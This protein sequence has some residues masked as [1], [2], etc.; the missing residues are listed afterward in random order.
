MKP[1]LRGWPMIRKVVLCLFALLIVLSA[2]LQAQF[3]RIY[4][5][6]G[7]DAAVGILTTADGGFLVM[8]TATGFTAGGDMEPCLIKLAADG[9]VQWGKAYNPIGLTA[10]NSICQA[11]DGGYLM[12]GGSQASVWLAKTDS[13][14]EPVWQKSLANDLIY[15]S[16]YYAVFPAGDAG[17]FVVGST[18]SGDF[19]NTW[20]VK[21]S[22]SGDVIWQR[23][24]GLDNGNPGKC[25]EA[26][27]DGGFVVA[28]LSGSNKVVAF[29]VD[30]LG[31][32]SWQKA[33]AALD[34]ANC[35]V[36]SVG[37]SEGGG[38]ILV[39]TLFNSD[40]WGGSDNRTGFVYKV[41]EDGTLQWA[42][43][44]AGAYVR[45]GS[46]TL[47]GGA[48]AVG[49]V[50]AEASTDLLVL[51]LRADGEI[52]W[53]KAFGGYYEEDGAT[54]V[55]TSEG[56]YAAAGLT[57]SFGAG[58]TDILAVHISPGG[59][60]GSCQFSADSILEGTIP[61]VTEED[62]SLSGGETAAG[63]ETAD[64]EVVDMIG[65][66]ETYQLCAENKLLTILGNDAGVPASATTPSLGTH[67]YANNEAV[68]ISAIATYLF[69]GTTY[70]FSQWE[71]DIYES[72]STLTMTM[73]DDTTI[74]VWYNPYSDDDGG[75]DTTLEQC[76]VATA[77][78]RSPLHP[79]VKL[80]REFRDRRLLTNGA[81]R[82]LVEA[83]YRWSPP[84][85]KVIAG[86]GVLRL[87]AR[88]LLVPVIAVAFVVLKLGWLG[89][90]LL[91]TAAMALIVRRGVLRR[92]A[93][94]A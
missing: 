20:V 37:R 25:G 28:G 7:V 6:T 88:V 12:A 19:A 81:G 68:T 83:Y 8:G 61:S 60:L 21:F 84:A 41:G 10:L 64:L 55:Q 23:A 91:T 76:F 42:R 11:P 82:A 93:R 92:R 29:K 24:F 13:A 1:E 32:I 69:N 46:A 80:L 17:Y 14:G 3:A 73:T 59:E 87:L 65:L 18:I 89:A 70:K 66:S 30:A 16:V 79:S 94:A 54:V 4:G 45:G 38:Y 57:G 26:T 74:R 40:D 22:S 71:G 34:Y 78:Y 33:Y 9:S 50:A 39:G 72:T 5:G 56:D 77:A 75:D 62:I 49:K 35:D 43:S 58:A 86:S 2:G 48:V 53:Q 85:A 51:K 52:E 47:D 27:A 15:E 67:I 31:D 36:V 90:L 63:S 44:F